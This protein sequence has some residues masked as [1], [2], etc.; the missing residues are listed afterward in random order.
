MATQ[1]VPARTEVPGGGP[2]TEFDLEVLTEELTVRELL[3]AGWA[4]APEV[5][6]E[7]G[8]EGVRFRYAPG[9]SLREVA[10]ELERQLYQHLFFAT[11]GDFERMAAR[12]LAGEDPTAARRVRLTPKRDAA[13]RGPG[14]AAGQRVDRPGSG[15]GGVRPHAPW[16]RR[17]RRRV[18]APRRR[19]PS[20]ASPT[21]SSGPARSRP[22]R[23][24]SR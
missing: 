13:A 7:G 8:G 23:R 24:P 6:E 14:R 17:A 5:E 20:A 12:L 10:R 9:S 2:A 4:D 15:G 11:K 21:W 19:G 1:T 16:P 3:R 18:G 22:T